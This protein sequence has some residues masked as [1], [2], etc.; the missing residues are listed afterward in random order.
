M[1]RGKD[2]VMLP[3]SVNAWPVLQ[4]HS[5]TH[6]YRASG[7]VDSRKSENALRHLYFFVRRESG[8]AGLE[9]I[10]ILIDRGLELL[11]S[12]KLLDVHFD[13]K[14]GFTRYVR[15]QRCSRDLEERDDE[16][17]RRDVTPGTLDLSKNE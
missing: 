5:N 2:Q 13:N 15:F 3:A 12:V 8:E 17:S 4:H 10:G 16:I 7:D 11:A 1:R 6:V 14:I 9:A